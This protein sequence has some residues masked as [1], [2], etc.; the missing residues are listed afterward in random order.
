MKVTGDNR[1]TNIDAYVKNIEDKK[2]VDSSFKQTSGEVVSKD[3]VV[4]SP[5]AKEIQKAKEILDSVP[6]IR[7]QK[8]AEI[9]TQ[10]EDGTYKID[11]EKIAL[12]VIEESLLNELL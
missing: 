8:V 12:K 5:K 9:K 7:K 3:E 6:D 4:L 2:R 10:I 1:F 11:G